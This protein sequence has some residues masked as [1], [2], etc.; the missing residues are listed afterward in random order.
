MMVIDRAPADQVP[1]W[2]QFTAD[3]PEI[4]IVSPAITRG[5]WKAYRD[6]KCIS[7]QLDLRRLLDDLGDKLGGAS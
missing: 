7:V 1:R 4:E 2:Q 3:H 5:M 6:G